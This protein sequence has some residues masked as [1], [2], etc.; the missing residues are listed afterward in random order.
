[1][2]TRFKITF[3]WL[4]PSISSHIMS[5]VTFKS[6]NCQPQKQTREICCPSARSNFVT[7]WNHLLLHCACKPNVVVDDTRRMNYK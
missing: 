3:D 5:L 6:F 7:H 1:M 4:T 2:V